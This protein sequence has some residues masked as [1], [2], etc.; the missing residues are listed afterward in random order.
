LK[1]L[2][3]EVEQEAQ[4]R[5]EKLNAA[6]AARAEKLDSLMKKTMK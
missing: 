5:G 6:A 1:Q 2:E 3:E 4:T